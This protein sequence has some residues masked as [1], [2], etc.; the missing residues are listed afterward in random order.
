MW[1]SLT[2]RLISTVTSSSSTQGV[3]EI[4]TLELFLGEQTFAKAADLLC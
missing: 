3:Y 1:K 2:A 4:N